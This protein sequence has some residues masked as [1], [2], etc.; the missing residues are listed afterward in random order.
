MTRALWLCVKIAVLVAAAVWLANRPGSVSVEWLGWRIENLPVGFIL[1]AILILIV[2]CALLYRLWR[3][4]Y[5]GPKNIGRGLENNRRRRGYKALNQG[6]V[7]VAAGA[8]D[9]AERFA[10]KADHLLKEAPLTK[11]LAAQAAQLKGD[12]SAAARYFEAML[13]DPETRFLGLR[14]LLTQ[15]M[16]DGDDT[17]A[18]DYV[19]QARSLQPRS[20]WVQTSLFELAERAGNFGEADEALKAAAKLKAVPADE[21]LRK[22]S[23]LLLE[24]VEKAVEA[25]DKNEALRLARGARKLAPYWLPANLAVA[26]Q[27]LAAGRSRETEKVAREAWRTAPHPDLASLYSL[28]G[29]SGDAI[30]QLK[31][32]GRLTEV[33]P[34]HRES[35]LT[36]AEAALTAKLWGEARRHL[37]DAAGSEP[38]VRVCH[39]MAKLEEAEH[40]DAQA[41]RDWLE[42]SLTAPL[43][44][45]WVCSGCG[46]RNPDWSAHCGVCDAF[47]SLAWQ[48]PPS[49]TRA[50]DQVIT[51]ET[52]P[53][54]PVLPGESATAKPNAL[55]REAAGAS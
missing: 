2:V 38:S 30:A 24:Q 3:F 53:A 33:F 44:P 19:R 10:R 55:P 20:P 6:M 17:A 42:R 28:T 25:G 12:E 46:A 54:K 40:G 39:L 34:D 4:L 50:P 52:A 11:L 49:L 9:E 29:G 5:R 1:L 47:D 21:A 7:A 8:P 16:K 27:A 13:E 51:I 14:G 18:L 26:R 35:H 23:A 37:Q 31:R 43:D 45:A 41:A 48:V 32:T 15:S 22:R 36:L